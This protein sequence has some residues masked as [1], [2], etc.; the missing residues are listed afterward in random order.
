MQLSVKNKLKAKD[1][2]EWSVWTLPEDQLTA[3]GSPLYSVL[4]KVTSA[5]PKPNFGK[6]KQLITRSS[7]KFYLS[8]PHKRKDLLYKNY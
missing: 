7:A 5:Q 1:E 3:V 2:M 4:V 8:K 6:L